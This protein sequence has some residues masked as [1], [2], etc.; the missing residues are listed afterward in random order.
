[1]RVGD[2]SERR[3]VSGGGNRGVVEFV[4]RERL[5]GLPQR[6]VGLQDG[7]AVAQIHLAL[8]EAGLDAEQSGHGVS[9]ALGIDP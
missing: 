5:A 1:M 2:H 6:P 4:A 3:I 8:G 7:A 9:D